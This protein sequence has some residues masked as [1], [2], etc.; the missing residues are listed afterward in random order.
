MPQRM[1]LVEKELIELAMARRTY[2]LRVVYAGMLFLAFYFILRE[3]FHLTVYQASRFGRLGVGEDLFWGTVWLQAVSIYF[4]MPILMADAIVGEKERRSLDL[5]LL[6]RLSEASILWQKLWSRIVP[7]LSFLMI[8][9]PLYAIAYMLGGVEAWMLAMAV[10]G[11]LLFTFCSGLI[12]LNLSSW[13]KTTIGALIAGYFMIPGML[14]AIV[15]I[16]IPTLGFAAPVIGVVFFIILFHTARTNLKNYTIKYHVWESFYATTPSES[17]ISTPT[18]G[19]LPEDEPV[20]WKEV[21]KKRLGLSHQVPAMILQAL[22]LLIFGLPILIMPS[23]A[24]KTTAYTMLMG[25]YS[26]LWMTAAARLGLFAVNSIASERSQEAL[27]IL[28]TTPMTA[29]EIVR[30]KFKAA[31]MYAWSMAIPLFAT[32]CFI[33]LMFYRDLV[34]EKNLVTVAYDRNLRF[35]SS[36]DIGFALAIGLASIFVLLLFWV[37]AGFLIGLS[38]RKRSRALFLMLLLIGV[39]IVALWITMGFNPYQDHFSVLNPFNAAVFFI[40]PM[41]L[42]D[43]PHH[44]ALKSLGIFTF[45]TLLLQR[46]ALGKAERL[47]AS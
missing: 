43:W 37:H 36:S 27:E 23:A 21:S 30:Q 1:P 32:L 3:N 18:S 44:L 2:V 9:L 38:V 16:S 11:M 39:N 6:T 41:D 15:F 45:L 4:F 33:C 25:A 40:W 8:S 22:P 31:Y 10:G 42:L 20:Y 19:S 12:C 26:L 47:L 7:M 29:K 34:R 13:T 17:P 5:L 28:R 14:L 35:L 46:I 24:E